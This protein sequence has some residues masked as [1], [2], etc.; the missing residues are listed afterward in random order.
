MKPVYKY[1][2][3]VSLAAI[4]GFGLLRFFANTQ[5]NMEVVIINNSNQSI[6]AVDLHTKKTGKNIR[7]RGVGVGTEVAVKFHNDGEDTFSLTV[8]FPDGKEIRGESVYI[9]PGYR[10]IESVTQEKIT[11]EH[12]LPAFPAN[13]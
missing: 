4:I 3:I 8:H 13:R 6:S 5:P 7:L 10:V 9:E 2:L 1:L 12:D 11:A